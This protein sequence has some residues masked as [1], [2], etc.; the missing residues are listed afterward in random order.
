VE[1]WTQL[2]KVQEQ[3]SFSSDIQIFITLR[4]IYV[5]QLPL[6]VNVMVRIFGGKVFIFK[7]EL[8]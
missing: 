8:L 5:Q 2:L 1:K 7:L 3:I 6:G 4:L